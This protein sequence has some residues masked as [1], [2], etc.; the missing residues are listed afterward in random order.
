MPRKIKM[1]QA[2][3]TLSLLMTNS[4]SVEI[5]RQIQS[6][7]LIIF[8]TEPNNKHV[9]ETGTYAHISYRKLDV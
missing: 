5:R 3:Q 9:S 4:V 6:L 7:Q 8:T 2:K 1:Q